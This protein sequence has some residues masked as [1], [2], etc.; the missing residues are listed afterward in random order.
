[1][2]MRMWRKRNTPPLLVGFKTNLTTQEINVLVC[3][4][5]RNSSTWRPGHITLG[6]Y[7]KDDRPTPPHPYHKDRCSTMFRPASFVVAR[8]WKQPRC[9]STEEWIWNI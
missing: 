7:P 2:L 9:P 5:I 1:M 8:S 4:K 6:I 3:Q